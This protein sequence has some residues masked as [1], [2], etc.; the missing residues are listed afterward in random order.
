MARI[1][2]VIDDPNTA[3]ALEEQLKQFGFAVE[4]VSTSTDALRALRQRPAE[5]VL[6]D[7]DMPTMDGFALL[8]ARAKDPAL[9]DVAVVALTSTAEGASA[10][11]RFA[12]YA[13]L[14][15]PLEPLKIVETFKRLTAAPPSR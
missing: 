4:V 14:R 8:R 15:K 2:V 10:A 6:V 3:N 7:L 13:C 1:I 9:A 12:P 5:A 11:R